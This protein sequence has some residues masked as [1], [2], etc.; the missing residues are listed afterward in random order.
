MTFYIKITYN[1]CFYDFF[2]TKTGQLQDGFLKKV[3][4]DYENETFKISIYLQN[5][6][7]YLFE[8]DINSIFFQP[9]VF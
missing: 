3:V 4:I 2:K 5:K 6:R 1:F 7:I 9:I 8:I